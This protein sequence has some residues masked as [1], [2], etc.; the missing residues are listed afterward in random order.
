MREREREQTISISKIITLLKEFFNCYTK[1]LTLK[2]NREN[3][4]R[5]QLVFIREK[6]ILRKK[7]VIFTL[8]EI[9][10]EL[11]FIKNSI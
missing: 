11:E 2:T 5:A 6:T 10:T 3:I 1:R 4:K 9:K 8:V 7:A